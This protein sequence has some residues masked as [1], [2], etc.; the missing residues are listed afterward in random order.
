MSSWPASLQNIVIPKIKLSV[1][2]PIYNERA[3]LRAV[4]ER[5]LSVPLEIELLCVDDGS[6][7]GSAEVL[8][9]LESEYPQV[10]V[11]PAAPQH[12]QGSRASPRYS[13]ATGDFVVIQDA[14]MEYDPADYHQP[15]RASLCGKS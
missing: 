3:T 14:D 13:E 9:E 1:V 7:D 2:M 5:V 6:S 11:L 10:R 15:H 12:G 4:V 8:R